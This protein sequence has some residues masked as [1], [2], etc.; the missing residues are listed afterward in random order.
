MTER[1]EKEEIMKKA[2]VCARRVASQREMIEKT[3]M[4]N[5]VKELRKQANLRQEDMARL[6]GVTRQTIIAIEVSRTNPNIK[7]LRIPAKLISCSF[8][9]FRLPNIEIRES[10]VKKTIKKPQRWRVTGV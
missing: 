6:L 10:P 8:I 7:K 1:K 5:N 9:P 4:R 2:G 3:E